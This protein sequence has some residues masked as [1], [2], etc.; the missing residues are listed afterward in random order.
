MTEYKEG[1]TDGYIFAKEE[2]V[3]RL[4]EVEGLD[5]WTIDQICNMIENNK[6]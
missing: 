1:F 2:L 3:E 6:L 4:S 5:D